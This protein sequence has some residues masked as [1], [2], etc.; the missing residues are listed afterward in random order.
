MIE[1]QV[2]GTPALPFIPGMELAGMVEAMGP[3]VD[4]PAVGTR[5]RPLPG[6]GGLAECGYRARRA[7]LPLPDGD[8]LRA[9]CRVPDRLWHLPSGAGPTAR[10]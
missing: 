7:L 3:G 5:V 9:R 2:P 1:G 4:G 8:G 6:T 10:D